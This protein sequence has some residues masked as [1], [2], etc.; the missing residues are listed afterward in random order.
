VIHYKDHVDAEF[1]VELKQ[2]NEHPDPDKVSFQT[3][4]IESVDA[5]DEKEAKDIAHNLMG[6][7][8]D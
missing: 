3:D 7:Y 8:N 2:H 4:L 1:V 5:Y 6:E